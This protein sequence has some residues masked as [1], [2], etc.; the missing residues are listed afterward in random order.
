MHKKQI[1][2]LWYYIIKLGIKNNIF[3]F[4][5]QKRIIL[6]NLVKTISYYLLIRILAK[7]QI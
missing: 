5:N 1:S 7:V 6:L 3:E 4:L 2:K